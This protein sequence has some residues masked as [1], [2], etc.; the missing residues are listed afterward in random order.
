M[1]YRLKKKSLT[2]ETRLKLAEFTPPPYVIVS[3]SMGRMLN[4]IGRASDEEGLSMRPAL[5]VLE[6]LGHAGLWG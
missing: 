4:L 5:L 1:L 6:I 3:P 2:L